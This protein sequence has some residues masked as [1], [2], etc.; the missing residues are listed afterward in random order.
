MAARRGQAL[1]E[2]VLVLA[3][4]LV[5]VT[6]LGFFVTGAVRFGVRTQ[7]LVSYECP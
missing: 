2:Y 3:A 1:F 7:T 5:V 4:M 6:V